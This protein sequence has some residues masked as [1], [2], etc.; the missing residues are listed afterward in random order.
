[1]R[2]VL[3][4]GFCVSRCSLDVK[5]LGEID[6][7]LISRE[8][9]LSVHV[10]SKFWRD[11]YFCTVVWVC[12]AAVAAAS[13]VVLYCTVH[14]VPPFVPAFVPPPC[15]LLVFS[16]QDTIFFVV[17]EPKLVSAELGK[18]GCWLP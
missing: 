12:V 14:V 2:C 7:C 16:A 13:G 5:L 10:S 17:F 1:M 15:T 18:R 9:H 4:A 3:L 6:R 8:M 11:L